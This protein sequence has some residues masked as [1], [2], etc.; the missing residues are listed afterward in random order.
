MMNLFGETNRKKS[1]Q[2]ITIKIS[3]EYKNKLLTE[4]FNE[5]IKY[6]SGR[7]DE[8]LTTDDINKIRQNVLN[9]FN[10]HIQKSSAK[11]GVDFPRESKLT[12]YLTR[13]K[14]D[15]SKFLIRNLTNYK[16]PQNTPEDLINPV[17]ETY[18]KDFSTTVK[19]CTLGYIN[20]KRKIKSYDE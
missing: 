16:I 20:S 5:R 14:E 15:K 12:L 19:Y 11:K 10:F 2:T 6:Y 1:V 17:L 3:D 9:M 4:I 13:D 7:L 8:D 18:K